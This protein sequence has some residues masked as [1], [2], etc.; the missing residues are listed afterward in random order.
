MQRPMAAIDGLLALIDLRKA[1]GLVLATGEVPTL[2]VGDGT[3][4]LSM[5]ALAP[6]MLEAFVEE[7]L[8]PPE[9]DRLPLLQ[10]Q[11]PLQLRHQLGDHSRLKA[12]REVGPASFDLVRTE[13]AAAVGERRLQ[14][15]EAEVQPRLARHRDLEE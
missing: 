3:R 1:Y 15:A 14:A 9:R 5:P 12:R 13:L 8:V 2:L 7:V 6:A 11:G 4:P 10:I